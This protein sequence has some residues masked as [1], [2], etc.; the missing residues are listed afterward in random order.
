M[1][2]E[3][4]R[5]DE[6]R[7]SVS[8]SLRI[9]Y[10]GTSS[11][12]W[13]ISVSPSNFDFECL[14]YLLIDFWLGGSSFSLLFFCSFSLTWRPANFKP[15]SLPLYSLPN[16]SCPS[17][18]SGRIV[19]YLHVR[20][21]PYKDELVEWINVLFSSDIM[22]PMRDWFPGLLFR[23]LRRSVRTIVRDLKNSHHPRDR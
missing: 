13:T 19:S 17:V 20:S 6:V 18:I 7:S 22:K 21:L 14:F 3:R 16:P 4:E 11:K 8:V 1:W 10:L 12:P 9:G 5:L 23:D 15:F 2:S